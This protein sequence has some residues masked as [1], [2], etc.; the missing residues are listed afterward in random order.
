MNQVISW[1]KNIGLRQIISVFLVT[2]AFL[3]VPALTHSKSMQAQA[4]TLIADSYT[5]DSAT[6]KR[7][8]QK[9]EDLGD[10]PERPIGQTGLKNI[11]KLGENIPETIK[12]NARQ[13]LGTDDPSD[14]LDDV[15][16][17]AERA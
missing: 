10:S 15:K 3:G 1:V 14:V 5:V 9:A 13:K 12:F 6:V 4:E 17:K 11:R 16:N 7:I 8:Q 2:I